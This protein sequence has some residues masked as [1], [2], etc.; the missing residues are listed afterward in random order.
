MSDILPSI[1][2]CER[3]GSYYGR[4]LDLWDESRDA[5]KYTGIAPVVA[6]P[7]CARW[8]CYAKS[9]E[10]LYGHRVGDDGGCFASALSTV[11]R[12]GGVI[13]H[14]AKSLA[15]T[16]FDLPKPPKGGGW[17]FD[18]N[19]WSCEVH[20]RV[21]GHRAVK[22]TWLYYEGKQPPFDLNWSAGA[23]PEGVVGQS[24]RRLKSTLPRLSPY[25]SAAT[26][27]AFRDLLIRLALHSKGAQ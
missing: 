7:P 18:G 17:I 21:Y 10:A 14:P 24:S 11:K 20:Q 4:G 26:P 1:L 2:F 3:F 25:E 23:P 8:C 16:A 15:W 12:V 27:P 5:R 19:G 9:I 13:E 22:K 6:H